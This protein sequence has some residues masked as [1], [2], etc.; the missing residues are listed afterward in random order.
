MLC[1]RCYFLARAVGKDPAELPQEPRLDADP[2]ALAA[3]IVAH[4]ARDGTDTGFDGG[5]W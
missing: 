2:A 5:S 3:D 4:D 1:G